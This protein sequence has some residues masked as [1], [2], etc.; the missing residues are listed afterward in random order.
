M[1]N[2]R[3]LVYEHFTGG[4][5][6]GQ[7]LPDE[8]V[9]AG[10]AMAVA[11][12]DDLAAAGVELCTLV[13]ARLLPLTGPGQVI[14]V[15]DA[16]QWQHCWQQALDWADAVWPIAPETDGILEN[17]SRD[18]VA[19]GCALLG[20]APEA[21]ALTASKL[22]TGHHLQQ[23]GIAIAIGQSADCQPDWPLPWLVKPDDGAGCEQNWLIRTVADWQ[24]WQAS[25]DPEHFIV[26]P[27][28]SGDPGSV[29]VLYLPGVSEL[30]AVQRQRIVIDGD[31]LQFDGI[32]PVEGS[33]PELSAL[34]GAVGQAIPGLWGYVG[35]D[36]IRTATGPVV[37]EINPRLTE[38]YIGLHQRSGR[39]PVLP[40]LENC[41]VAVDV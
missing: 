22:A 13:D 11:L 33:D 39:N 18:I 31:R 32:E 3:A 17:L 4:G 1:L 6:A 29:I 40:I 28:L 30:I 16:E 14:P 38:S 7:P 25:V 19:A 10:R 34:V 24:H 5:L 26:Q 37:I 20:S 36:F 2:L 8:L 35:I 27:Y 23:A 12:R 21:I 41:R 9:Q 15:A